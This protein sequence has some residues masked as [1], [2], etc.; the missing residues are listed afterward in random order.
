MITRFRVFKLLS[1]VLIS[2]KQRL[3][4]VCERWK[5]SWSFIQSRNEWYFWSFL[6][7]RNGNKLFKVTS[8]IW[9]KRPTGET[10]KFLWSCKALGTELLVCFLRK[11]VKRCLVIF[12]AFSGWCLCED[13]LQVSLPNSLWFELITIHHLQNSR[14]SVRWISCPSE[15]NL[16]THT[17]HCGE[18]L[19]PWYDGKLN[20]VRNPSCI[21]TSIQDSVC[22]F[23][24]SGLQYTTNLSQ[25]SHIP[26]C[27]NIIIAELICPLQKLEKEHTVR[28]KGVLGVSG[29]CVP[30]NQVQVESGN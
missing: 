19:S 10:N 25:L 13:A 18:L 26:K 2:K 15:N 30:W 27:S 24:E 20:V 8:A 5:N 14:I 23:V 16:C 3:L 29:L 4:C 12:V 1:L 21:I 9:C 22:S 11:E 17:G 28:R 6:L 7:K